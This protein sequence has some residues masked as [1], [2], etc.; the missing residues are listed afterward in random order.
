MHPFQE[1]QDLRASP[2]RSFSI[3]NPELGLRAMP[4]LPVIVLQ[5]YEDMYAALF[6]AREGDSQMRNAI[7][8][9]Y[10]G[11]PGIGPAAPFFFP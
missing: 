10:I 2:A 9:L 8:L 5:A 1:V 4:G 3:I 6:A 11:H 7:R